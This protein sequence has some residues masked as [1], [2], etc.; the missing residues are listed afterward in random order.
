MSANT[1]ETVDKGHGDLLTYGL[2]VVTG[3][4]YCDTYK[5]RLKFY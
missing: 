5:A 1:K 3:I 2:L 4:H